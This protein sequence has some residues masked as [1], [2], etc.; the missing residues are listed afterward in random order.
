MQ[1]D[2][3]SQQQ[4]SFLSSRRRDILLEIGDYYPDPDRPTVCENVKIILHRSHL[5]AVNAHGG[6]QEGGGR[7][8]N[9]L[10]VDDQ[11]TGGR[12]E[13]PLTKRHEQYLGRHGNETN[14]QV[15]DSQVEQKHADALVT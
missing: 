2:R 9:N 13:Y 3:L 14:H 5:V 8:C 4:L 7:Q 12:T 15:P 6:Q 1:Y 11:L 10:S